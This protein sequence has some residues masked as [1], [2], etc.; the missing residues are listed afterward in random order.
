MEIMRIEEEIKGIVRSK[1]YRDLQTNLQKLRRR[2]GSIVEIKS[3]VDGKK[4]QVRWNSDESQRYIKRYEGQMK[5]YRTRLDELRRKKNRL[6][7]GL[8]E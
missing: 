3:L 1:R 7:T 8:F 2:S 5:E 6:T 4:L